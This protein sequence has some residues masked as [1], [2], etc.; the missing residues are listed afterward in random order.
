LVSCRKC[1]YALS[2]SSTRTSARK[3]HYYRCLGSDAWRHLGG[4]VCDCRPVRQDLLDRIVWQEVIHLIENPTLIR[5]ELDRRLDA[6]RAAE[7]TK[8]RREA[9]ERE[10]T[11]IRKSM[12]RLITAYQEDLLSLDE[13]RCRM[14]ELRAREQSVRAERQAI[15]DQ[16]ADQISF[17]RL[18][19]TLTAFLQRLRQSAETLEIAERQ[20]VVRLLVKEVLVD[21][22][23]IT[24]RHSIPAQPPTSPAGGAPLLSNG[25]LRVGVESYLLR[26]GSAHRPLWSATAAACYVAIFRDADLQPFRN[27]SEACA[28]PRYDARGSAESSC[29]SWHQR[30]LP[31]LAQKMI[32][33]PLSRKS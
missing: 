33:T 12:E 4:A 1:G 32:T 17:L 15:L 8:R 19:E 27:S 31:F 14:P 5:A 20:K 29:G 28:C 10:L 22:D 18:A 30:S 25:K 3:I 26:S 23:T 24:I 2:R 6:A 16:A 7:P 21:N 13:L 11:R 9:L